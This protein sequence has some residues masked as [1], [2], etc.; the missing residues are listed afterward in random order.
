MFFCS[1]EC[2][3]CWPI[4]ASSL[5]QSVVWLRLLTKPILS[6][7]KSGGS[8]R[9]E[10]D[11]SFSC[12][13]LSTKLCIFVCFQQQEWGAEPS[14]PTWTLERV[15]EVRLVSTDQ[16]MSAAVTAPLFH[17]LFLPL[18]CLPFGRYTYDLSWSGVTRNLNIWF[19]NFTLFL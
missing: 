7:R 13:I 1:T 6:K 14:V 8:C 12:V 2:G 11:F 19:V 10:L 4:G 16:N 15:A 18:C 5:T 3:V 9:G 17:F